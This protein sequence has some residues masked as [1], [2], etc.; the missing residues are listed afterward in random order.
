M[1]NVGHVSNVIFT[2]IEEIVDLQGKVKLTGNDHGEKFRKINNQGGG[3]D[4][5]RPIGN[6]GH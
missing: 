2:Y 1:P 6:E 4:E 5:V 3:D